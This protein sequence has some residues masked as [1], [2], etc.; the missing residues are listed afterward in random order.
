MLLSF[1]ESMDG[2]V[3]SAYGSVVRELLGMGKAKRDMNCSKIESKLAAILGEC[4]A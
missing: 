4:M 2:I 3:G 1:A